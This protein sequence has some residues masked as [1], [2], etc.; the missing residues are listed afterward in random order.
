MKKQY[1]FGMWLLLTI[2]TCGIYNYFFIA[3][4]NDSVNEVS[5]NRN[6]TSGLM[7]VL[8]SII[9]C[10]IYYY[11]WLYNMG[12]RIRVAGARKNITVTDSGSTIILWAILGSFLCGIGL[13]VGVFKLIENYNLVE[14]V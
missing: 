1:S 13:Y 10:G 14:S 12:E 7:V 9:T 5:D 3:S 2:V 8:L 11:I 4:F 6:E